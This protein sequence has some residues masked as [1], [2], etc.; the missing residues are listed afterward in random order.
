MRSTLSTFNEIWKQQLRFSILRD[1]DQYFSQQSF[2]IGCSGGMDSM[3]LLYLMH[4]LFPQRV[5]AI[6]IDHQLQ[7][8]SKT[9][10]VMVEDFCHQ[11]NIPCLVQAVEVASGNLEQQARHA[12]YTAFLQHKQADEVLVLAHHQQDQAETV[13]LRLLSG[14]GVGGLAAMRAIDVREDFTI[15]RPLLD[16]SREQ[17]AQW[18]GQLQ[19]PYIDDP[20]NADSHYDRAWC[21]TELW[22]V[23][24]QRFPQMQSALARNAQ[25]MQD[26][27]DILQEVVQQDWQQCGDHIYLNLDILQQLTPARQRQLLSAWMKGELTYRPSLDAVLRLQQ[28]VIQSRADAQACLF[29]KPYYY[30]RFQKQIYRLTTQQYLCKQTDVIPAQQQVRW[31]KQQP[32]TLIS[33]EYTC[34]ESE[35]GLSPEL[36]DTPLMLYPRVGGEKVH[37]YGRVGAWPLKKALQDA[38]IFPWLRHRVQI[39]AKDDVILGVFTPQGFWLAQS[40]YCQ[41]G[42]W[43]PK[44]IHE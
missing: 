20:T 36:L 8:P 33:G 27:D 10:G 30:V 28:E 25:L 13:L 32:V 44:L 3:L 14:A 21:R 34:R 37:L 42:G 39:L 31:K 2:L 17:I 15:W 35:Y 9:W 43:Q 19:L 4:S 16:I 1:A 24:Q 29:I 12:R 6:Y 5:R 22:Q 7:A 11:F 41:H 23:L 18:V 40:Y 38:Q 26:A